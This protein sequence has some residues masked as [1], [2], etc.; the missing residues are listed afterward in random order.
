[1]ITSLS[2]LKEYVVADLYRY[3]TCVTARAFVRCWFTPGFRYT[4]F[5]RCCQFSA[6]NYKGPLFVLLFFILRH[7]QFKY[8][9]SI[10]YTT[11]VGKGL[12]IGHFGGI[13]VNPSA[14]IGQNVNFSPNV[15]LGLSYNSEL[16]KFE[17]PVIGD[18]VYLGNGVKVIGG[19][20]IGDDALVGAGAVVTKDLP[21]KA[22]AV[23][24]PA[25]M[26][27][28]KGSSEYVGSYIS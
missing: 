11:E 18:R 16:K 7:Y 6:R 12:Y 14:R 10:H 25:K 1:M 17:F 20:V 22:V 5:L 28:Q 23:G 26:I 2:Q 4:F 27:S 9:I 3:A 13:I 19:V 24:I 15:L 8:G 21:A